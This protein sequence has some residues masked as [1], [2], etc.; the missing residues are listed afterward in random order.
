MKFILAVLSIFLF[1][2]SYSQGL[3][4]NP[5]PGSCFVR[6][7]NEDDKQFKWKELDC[8][9]LK[10][11][12]LDL[13]FYSNN[14]VLSIEDKNLIKNRMLEYFNDGVTMQIASHFD[15]SE[16]SSVNMMKSIKYGVTVSDFLYSIGVD[17]S[18]IVVTSYGNKKPKK[19]CLENVICADKIYNKNTR[20][21]YRVINTGKSN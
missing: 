21:E 16:S 6:C 13:E 3:P 14:G 19:K 5:E 4:E 11:R 18:R 1:Q 12:E 10:L 15:S 8:D 20:I 2:F 9:I 17:S 7:F